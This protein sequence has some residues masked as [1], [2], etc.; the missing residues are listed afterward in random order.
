MTAYGKL[1]LELGLESQLAEKQLLHLY[2]LAL[3]HISGPLFPGP[4]NCQ[5]CWDTL[6][7]PSSIH[8]QVSIPAWSLGM[9]KYT[10]RHG[11]WEA[12]LGPMV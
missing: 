12:L 4:L 3:Q 2:L 8:I 1:D 6:Q 7:L 11:N 9:T 10:S 5:A